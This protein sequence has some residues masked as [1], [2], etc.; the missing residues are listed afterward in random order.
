M[1]GSR[2]ETRPD[3]G[4]AAVRS[5]IFLIGVFAALTVLMLA[6]LRTWADEDVRT[7]PV[8]QVAF[9]I[10]WGA[11]MIWTHV[12]SFLIGLDCLEHGLEG[13]NQAVVWAWAGLMLGTTMAVA[14]A[15]IGQGPT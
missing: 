10:A 7:L 12:V 11:A 13:R 9:L 2:I 8:Y 4:F 15:N 6:V 14:G 5:A 1:G 3:L